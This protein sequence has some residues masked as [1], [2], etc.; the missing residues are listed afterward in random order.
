MAGAS[1]A[2]ILLVLIVEAGFALLQRF[3]VSPGV[4]ARTS[5]RVRAAGTLPP[6][7]PLA[8]PAVV[9]DDEP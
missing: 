2:I 8:P 4:R 7:A 5:R 1:I 9:E 6:V 3:A